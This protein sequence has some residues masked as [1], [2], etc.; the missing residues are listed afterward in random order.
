MQI[1]RKIIYEAAINGQCY[2]VRFDR[3]NNVPNRSHK[4]LII[5]NNILIHKDWLKSGFKP[6]KK[7]AEFFLIK[8]LTV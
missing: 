1:R 2:T 4:V 7:S 5:L 8:H 6:S 3:V